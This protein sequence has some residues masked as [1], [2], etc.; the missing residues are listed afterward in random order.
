MTVVITQ[1]AGNGPIYL[2]VTYFPRLIH[3]DEPNGLGAHHTGTEVS[4]SLSSSATSALSS[5]SNSA[6][7]LIDSSY[8]FSAK[9]TYSSL[10]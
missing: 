1:R 10:R 9:D 6:L 7:F 5:P 8:S 3:P 2:P 4:A